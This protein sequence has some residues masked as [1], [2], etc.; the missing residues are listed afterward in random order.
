MAPGRNRTRAT[1]LGRQRSH[2]CPIPAP[3]Y[4]RVHS[5]LY[6]RI[7]V[8]CE[9][10]SWIGISVEKVVEPKTEEELVDLEC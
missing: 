9:T 6:L 3:V 1:L 4:C 2:H 5:Y 7:K 10:S 8:S